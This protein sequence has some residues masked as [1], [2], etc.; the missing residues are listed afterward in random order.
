MAAQFDV[1][2]D[3][4]SLGSAPNPT[5]G[6]TWCAWVRIDVD[7]NA[8]TTFM[9]LHANTGGS[10]TLTVAAGSD[11]ATPR[12]FSPGN[13]SGAISST[14]MAVGSWYF[15]AY[16]ISAANAVTLYLMPE[17]GSMLTVTA[18]VPPG[19]TP[20]GLTL[21]GRSPGDS[22]EWLAGSMAYVRLWSGVL[23]NSTQLTAEADSET[24]VATSGL[25]AHWPLTANLS[26]A[27]GNGRNLTPGATAVTYVAGPDIGSEPE[28]VPEATVAL[29]LVVGV[30]SAAVTPT[31]SVP[32][33]A[34]SL[35][36]H[37][38]VGPAATTP[39]ASVQSATVT[40]PLELDIT[41]A[42]V[43]PTATVPE[44]TV[45]L[46]LSVTLTPAA[47]LVAPSIPEAATTLPILVG[48][49]P[50]V[51]SP[52][53]TVPSA[54]FSLPLAVGVGFAA[55]DGSE[56]DITLTAVL[57]QQTRIT[58]SL[59]GRRWTASLEAQP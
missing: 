4:V 42:A 19:T 43:A 55:S 58:S 57:A 30:A 54:A 15:V 33:A 47:E 51:V 46:P 38:G 26:D 23:L 17:G 37:I 28:P 16:T 2:N 24:P 52:T 45:S 40:L 13:T 8:F 22:D 7:R 29:P 10:T 44:A 20:T 50:T 32:S 53:A 48:L 34:V 18:T 36:L 59:G 6:M 14:A 3:R 35:P 12:V 21:A 56:Q 31:A 11:G 25:W 5:A 9:R 39:T 27:S 41:A 1:A 49:A